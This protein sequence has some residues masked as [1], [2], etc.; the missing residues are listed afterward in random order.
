MPKQMQKTM[1]NRMKGFL[2][3]EIDTIA[4]VDNLIVA[5]FVLF[6]HLSNAA[7]SAVKI[8]K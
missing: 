4:S 2:P 7:Y 1:Y 3:G 5:V 6:K 8:I